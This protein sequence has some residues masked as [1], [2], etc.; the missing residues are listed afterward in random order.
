MPLST[1]LSAYLLSYLLLNMLKVIRE[2]Q[3]VRSLTQ[4]TQKYANHIFHFAKKVSSK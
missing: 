2:I 4:L 1:S 3:K